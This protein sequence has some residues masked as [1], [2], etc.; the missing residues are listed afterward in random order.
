MQKDLAKYAEMEIKTQ[1]DIIKK[2]EETLKETAD[3]SANINKDAVKTIAKS[4]KEGWTEGE[5]T[6]IHCKHCGKQIDADSTFCKYC[7]KTI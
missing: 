1:N 7:G 6:Q 2:N 3:I 4:A 5:K